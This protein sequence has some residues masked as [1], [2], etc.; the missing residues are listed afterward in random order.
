MSKLPAPMKAQIERGI[1]A[2]IVESAISR[3][4]GDMASVRRL[5]T[6]EAVPAD[7]QGIA[8]LLGAGKQAQMTAIMSQAI[9]LASGALSENKDVQAALEWLN[10]GVSQ[11]DAMGDS[12]NRVPEGSTSWE[13]FFQ[14]EFAK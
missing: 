8:E 6:D 7:S 4:G 14:R 2:D 1:V 13:E 9:G 10:A 3:G 11:V 12:V 5:I